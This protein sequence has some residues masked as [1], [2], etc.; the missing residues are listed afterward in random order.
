MSPNIEKLSDLD[1]VAQKAAD[2]V[3]RGGVVLFPTDT[4]YGLGAD[5]MSDAAVQKIYDI[6]GRDEGKPIHAIVADLAMADR[7]GV[8]TD[9]VR[10]L[11][12]ELPAGKL[13]FILKKRGGESGILKGL[14]TFG[15]RIPDNQFCIAL[16]RAFG[17]PITATSA[18]KSGSAPEP[19]VPA[20][21]EQLGGGI[22]LVVDAGELAPSQP[23][24]VVD[25]SGRT[26]VIVREGAVPA[27]DVWDTLHPAE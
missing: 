5:A 3:R 2:V 11:A 4:L 21:L 25:V 22:D 23:S 7:Y 24:T 27:A 1:L 18:N 14:G 8:V 17:G 19:L 15:F 16:V 6:K 26:P 10:R 12:K 9:D 13:T 20:I